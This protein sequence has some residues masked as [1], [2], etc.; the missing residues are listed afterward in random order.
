MNYLQAEKE[1]DSFNKLVM[2]ICS[3]KLFTQFIKRRQS[4]LSL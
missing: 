3:S 1:E 2:M 4:S